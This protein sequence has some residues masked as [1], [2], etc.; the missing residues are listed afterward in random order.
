MFGRLREMRSA[1]N[2]DGRVIH[3]TL[4]NNNTPNNLER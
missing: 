2:N 1:C 3:D 4:D